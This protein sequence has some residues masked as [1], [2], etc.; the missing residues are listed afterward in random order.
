MK[1]AIMQPYLFPYIGYFQLINAVEEFVIYD[2]IEYS[3]K[4]WINRNRILANAKDIYI[5]IPLK[6]ESDYLD[7]KDRHLAEN[8][9][10]ERGK[11][12]NKIIENYKKSPFYKS[13]FP[14]IE[15]CFFFENENLFEFIKNSIFQINNYLNIKTPIYSSSS[16]SNNRLLKS[17]HRVIEICKIRGANI[18]I[19]P[20]GGVN[21]YSKNV[22]INNNIDLSFLKSNDIVYRQ[23][24]NKFVPSLSI[25]DVL[26]FNSR[27]EIRE[28]L[29]Q[30]ELV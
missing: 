7:I 18:Y 26:M 12:I 8:W 30:Y 14:L 22:F 27:T 20:I 13:V 4:G 9:P 2:N 17:H 16:I 21:L 19:N 10:L 3:K 29:N 5:S 15:N 23:F 28:L 1:I 11:V 24:E 6:K 25:I